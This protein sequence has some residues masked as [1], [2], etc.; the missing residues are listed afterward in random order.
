MLFEYDSKWY[1]C[2]SKEKKM[3]AIFLCDDFVF[4]N[5]IY[6]DDLNTLY[7]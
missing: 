1:K 7:Q 5:Y 4:E 2:F 6:F 3:V